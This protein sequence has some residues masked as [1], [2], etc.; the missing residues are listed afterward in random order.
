MKQKSIGINAILNGGKT[1]LNMLFP[2]ITFPYVS[3]V[4]QSENLGKYNFSQ[5]IITYFIM[6]AG[7]GISQYAIRE[8]AKYRDNR[9]QYENF[10]S[11]V[12]SINIISSLISYV[13]LFI[14][15]FNIGKL[16]P[17]RIIILIF[18]LEIFFTTIGTEWIFSTFEEYGYITVRS[19][20]FKVI[21]MLL[22]FLLV[23]DADDYLKYAGITVFANVGA[24]SLN[25]F[26]LKKR[27]QLHFTLKCNWER[28][29][30]PVLIMFA[31][32]IA[33]QIYV[34]SDMTMLG[35]MCNDKVVGIYTV[36]AKIYN[37][38]KNMLSAVL[39]VI[40]P[41]AALLLGQNKHEEYKKLIQDILNALI[42]LVVPAVVGLFCL[43]QEIVDLIAGLGY[44][45]ANSSLR[46]L[47][48]ALLFCLMG[49]LFNDCVLIPARKEK[50][51]LM[52]TTI[53]AIA[54]M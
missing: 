21:S 40:I 45:Q 26:Y 49:W 38:V 9:E 14:C 54:N 1:V 22:L 34:N 17:Y 29:L 6:I 4:L 8:G 36:A 24:N 16:Y 41:R 5:S 11:E 43:S 7:L 44:E 27:C 42:V 10:A 31:S 30:P 12:F 33:I 19:I 46:L 50:I 39:V 37:I 28:H 13:L 25:Y 2:L 47:S 35:L 48:I 23:K 53:S 32:S 51:V 20:V 18:S 3:R 52:A 15:V